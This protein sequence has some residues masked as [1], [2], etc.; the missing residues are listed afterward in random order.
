[1]TVPQRTLVEV[2]SALSMAWL[3][4]LLIIYYLQSVLHGIS[5]VF[6]VM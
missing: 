5:M 2:F 6:K 3:V 1:M 4:I